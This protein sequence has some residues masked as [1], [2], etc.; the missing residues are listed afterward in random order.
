MHFPR[1]AEEQQARFIAEFADVELPV[2]MSSNLGL[3]GAWT[4]PG[5]TGTDLLHLYGPLS[6][7]ADLT[8]SARWIAQ[9]PPDHPYLRLY[10]WISGTDIRYARTVRSLLDPV[11]HGWWERRVQVPLA[12]PYFVAT[13]RYGLTGERTVRRGL[14]TAL[15]AIDANG[16]VSVAMAYDTLFGDFGSTRVI[17][18]APTAEIFD[19]VLNEHTAPSAADRDPWAIA[20]AVPAPYSPLR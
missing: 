5:D 15:R 8:A 20:A 9:L 7:L 18:T 13:C 14:S 6:G 10:E 16:Q 19:A 11:D 3:A 2:L 17:G 4:I 1:T 12:A